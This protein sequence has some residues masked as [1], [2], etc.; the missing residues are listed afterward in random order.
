MGF[1]WSTDFGSTWAQTPC[2]PEKPLF[3]EQ[4][5]HGEPVKIGAPHFVDF[6]KDLEHSPDG[7]AY[8]VAQGASDGENRRYAYNSWITADQVYLIRAVPSIENMNDPAK[9]EF[10]AG[11]DAAGKPLWTSDFGKI[12]PLL[13]WNNNMGD[14]T[15]TSPAPALSAAIPAI[16]AAPVL[17]RDPAMTSTRPKSPLCESADRTGTIS[18]IRSRVRSST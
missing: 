8:L 17:P 3:A 11:H 6:G 12:K 10:F 9:Y 4:S 5:P 1:R 16:A 15:V 14:A 18:R 7:K 2:T 13:D